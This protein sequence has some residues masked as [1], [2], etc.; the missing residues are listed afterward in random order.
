MKDQQ[1][2]EQIIPALSKY[3]LGIIKIK[4]Q[5]PIYVPENSELVTSL[6]EVY[7]K[8]TGDMNSRP[9]VIGGGTYARVSQKYCSFWCDFSRR[10]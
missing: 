3:N 8:H 5:E 7:K 10:T 2:Y 9:L 1:I 6:M 4:N